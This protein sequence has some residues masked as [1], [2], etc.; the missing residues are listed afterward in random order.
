MSDRRCDH[1]HLSVKVNTDR[2]N[3]QL[4]DYIR[5][6]FN[7]DEELLGQSFYYN[8]TVIQENN[9]RAENDAFQRSNSPAGGNHKGKDDWQDY[10]VGEMVT[11]CAPFMKIR[12][13]AHFRFTYN[14]YINRPAI[15]VRNVG[16]LHINKFQRRVEISEDEAIAIAHA[17][18]PGMVHRCT[19][20]YL[21]PMGHPR[22][23][24]T[25]RIRFCRVTNFPQST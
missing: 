19:N 5:P 16:W 13:C 23:L 18:P 1:P 8:P 14:Q 22:S 21:C 11:V 20:K 6:N 12:N 4:I 3:T 25:F 17:S 24:Y 7:D 9:L 15:I 10:E 2:G